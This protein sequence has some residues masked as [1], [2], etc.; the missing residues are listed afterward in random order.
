MSSFED[1]YQRLLC[2]THGQTI[3]DRLDCICST[4]SDKVT[5]LLYPFLQ[6]ITDSEFTEWYHFMLLDERDPATQKQWVS[7]ILS[8]KNKQIRRIIDLIL[9]KC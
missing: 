6:V 2:E 8:S 1:I 7:K 9:A 4:S 3:H 5:S